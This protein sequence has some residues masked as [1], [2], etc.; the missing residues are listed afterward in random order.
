[1]VVHAARQSCAVVDEVELASEAH[2]I[3]GSGLAG[4][5][6]EHGANPGPELVGG[7]LDEAAGRCFGGRGDECA[8]VEVRL[9]VLL[10]LGVEDSHE[11]PRAT[12]SPAASG[13]GRA[14]RA[15]PP[16]AAAA[17]G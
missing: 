4:E 15:R 13:R 3:G 6:G 16:E 2:W 8:A 12:R 1:V 5:I 9:L 7:V 10:G 11:A 17:G 14:T